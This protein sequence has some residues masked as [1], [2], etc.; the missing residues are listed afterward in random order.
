MWFSERPDEIQGAFRVRETAAELNDLHRHLRQVILRAPYLGLTL[1]PQLSALVLRISVERLSERSPRELEGQL[2]VTDTHTNKMLYRREILL[3]NIASV[4][5][6]VPQLEQMFADI[7]T[8]LMN[9]VGP[10]KQ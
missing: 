4:G 7:E 6:L 3:R 9:S 10:Q 8:S 5:S 2:E 1:D